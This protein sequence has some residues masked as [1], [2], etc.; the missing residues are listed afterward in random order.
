MNLEHPPPPNLSQYV[1]QCIVQR[2]AQTRSID[3]KP[4]VQRLEG[5]LLTLDIA[6]FSTLT[7]RLTQLGPLG[8]ELLS[9]VLNAYFSHMTETAIR[10]GGD[11]IDFIGDGII[12]LWRATDN[13]EVCVLLAT[14]CAFELQDTMQLISDD[15]GSPLR[16]RALIS[17]GW[18]NHFLVGGSNGRWYS[19]FAGQPLRSTAALFGKAEP[20]KIVAAP[21]AWSKLNAFAMGTMRQDGSVVVHRINKQLEPPQRAKVPVP[22]FVD[23]LLESYVSGA[24]V[25]QQQTQQKQWLAGFRTI[26]TIF[27]N[28]KYTDIATP[29]HLGRTQRVVN[30]ID[31]AATR[32]QGSFEQLVMDDKGVSVLVAFGIPLYAHEDDPIRAVKSALLVQNELANEGISTSTG[33]TTGRLFYGD[34]G[35]LARRHT[36]IIGSTIN[37][38]ARLMQAANGGILCDPATVDAV[39]EAFSFQPMQALA[40]KGYAEAIPVYYLREARDAVPPHFRSTLIGRE[41]ELARLLRHLDESQDSDRLVVVRGEAGI[42][43]SRLLADLIEQARGRDYRVLVTSGS[44]IEVGTPYFPWRRILSQLLSDGEPFDAVAARRKIQSILERDDRLLA[45]SSLLNDLLPLELPENNVV[46]QMNGAARAN[47]LYSVIVGL[48]GQS[49]DMPPILVVLDDLHWIDEASAASFSTL[50][51]RVDRLQI[52]AAS[53]PLD[54]DCGVNLTQLMTRDAGEIIDLEPLSYATN[55]KLINELLEV[56]SVPED[57]LD[58]VFS[59]TEGH[60]YYTEALLA[61][62]KGSGLISVTDGRCTL[63]EN[64][65]T[66]AATTVPD[67]LQGVIVSRIDRLRPAE[68]LLLRVAS[69]L[70]R[71]FPANMLIEIYPLDEQT[72]DLEVVVQ[73]LRDED[74]IRHESGQQAGMLAFKHVIFQ[75]TTYQLLLYA[76]RRQ[77]HAGA[78]RWIESHYPTQREP[79]YAELA[80]HWEK[81]GFIGRS[82]H[83]SERAGVYALEQ[84]ALR[85]AITHLSTCFAVAKQHGLQLHHARQAR[86]ETALGDAYHELREYDVAALHYERAAALCRQ[87]LPVGKAPLLTNIGKQAIR[88]LRLRLLPRVTENQPRNAQVCLEVASHVHERIAEIAYFDDRPL[89]LLFSTLASLNL[90]EQT[91]SV[92][93]MVNGYAALS[94][95]L[96]QAG[97]AHIASFYNRRSLELAKSEGTLTD[98]AW[99][100]MVNMVYSATQ[101]KWDEV[102]HS[103]D[104]SARGYRKLGARIRWQTVKSIACFAYFSTGQFSEATEALWELKRSETR[105]TPDQILA[106]IYAADMVIALARDDVTLEQIHRLQRAETSVLNH[107]DRLLCQGL[108]ARG[109]MRLGDIG[110]ALVAADR[111][112]ATL[113]HHSPTAWH[114]TAGIA[115]AAETYLNALAYDPGTQDLRSELQNRSLAACRALR[116]HA[117]K[118]PVS[119]PMAEVLLGRYHL[120]HG[121]HRRARGLWNRAI[122]HADRLQMPYEKALALYHTGHHLPT[123]SAGF[124]TQLHKSQEI[125]ER[126]GATYQLRRIES[127]TVNRNGKLT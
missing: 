60:P 27:I 72:E 79:F 65:R 44:A 114:I 77:L 91:H 6:R 47:A 78:A 102:H 30:C 9:E 16:Q 11:I 127:L 101:G 112:L 5:A 32:Y 123:N 59:R 34:T 73:I 103:A 95:G 119:R 28:F 97:A 89:P 99:S 66:D 49:T 120:E 48:L 10:Y 93:E 4:S 21:E 74:I 51:E 76:Q 54:Q 23:P 56:K 75:E 116:N 87:P 20:G 8:A 45:W 105:E 68:Q 14:Q 117:G 61:E 15:T 13:L 31:E 107:S 82:V 63:N 64:F 126:L 57:L 92:S 7:D 53:R 85:E 35:G 69:V 37:L 22:P 36:T 70:G 50:L 94:V 100:H 71:E 58:F 84:Y 104:I 96:L 55:A 24:L 118:A 18:L 115:G 81:A 86:W 26:T 17:A 67:S 125:F 12:V 110:A 19:L 62:L 2:L 121:H 38:A 52:I 88:Q 39:G 124:N 111:A 106:W 98:F 109:M 46:R 90:A 122:T 29:D 41:S 43:K 113:A 80:M 33:I 83:Y 108:I 25:H 3:S 42:G 1:P 40:V